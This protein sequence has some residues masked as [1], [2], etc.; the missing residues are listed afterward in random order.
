MGYL[1]GITNTHSLG[2]LNP[3][4]STKIGGNSQVVDCILKQ[5]AEL[6]GLVVTE[7]NKFFNSILSGQETCKFF[8]NFRTVYQL[9]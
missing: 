7:R 2:I 6:Q 9:V 5:T 3:Y 4:T 1:S 8:C